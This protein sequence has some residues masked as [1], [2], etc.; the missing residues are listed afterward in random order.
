[1]YAT[2]LTAVQIGWKEDQRQLPHQTSFSLPC[3]CHRTALSVKA[4][5]VVSKKMEKLGLEMRLDL[6]FHRNQVK[7]YQCK[8]WQKNPQ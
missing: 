8:W 3:K 6:E 1:M 4:T 7:G 2:S 5:P